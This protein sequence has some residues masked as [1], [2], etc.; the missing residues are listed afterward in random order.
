[1]VQNTVTSTITCI[2]K[3]EEKR[4]CSIAE[5]YIPNLL[6]ESPW[7]YQNRIPKH[8]PTHFVRHPSIHSIHAIRHSKMVPQVQHT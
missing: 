4:L 3:D 5:M 2:V 7:G 6:K 8:S 1:M